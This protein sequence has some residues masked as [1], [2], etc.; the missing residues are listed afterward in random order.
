MITQH[1]LILASASP[2]RTE[3]LRQIGIPHTVRP[4]NILEEAPY[5]MS[6]EDYVM[7]L[8]QK[9]ARA[10]ARPG[11]IVLAA[12]TVVALD[13]RILEKPADRAAALEMLRLLSGRT[14]EVV[15][16]VTLLTD[17]REETFTVTTTVRFCPLP[18]SWMLSYIAT[19]EPYDKAGG[20][21]I[22]GT[23]GLFVEA[24]D[25]DYYNV[26]GLPINPISRRLETFGIK[27]MFA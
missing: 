18:E 10:V 21:G 6:S 5:P 27:P 1:Q 19:D 2:R 15:T 16:G 8:S 23:G 22:Q 24:I 3:L 26:V 13:H 20:Y 4:A 25:G 7:Y 17:E 14:H 12:D 9:K 11:E